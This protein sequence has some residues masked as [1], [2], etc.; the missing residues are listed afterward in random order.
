MEFVPSNIIKTPDFGAMAQNAMQQ[1][2]QDI[3]EMNDWMD[4]NKK[5]EGAYL[6]GDK[7]A[8][9]EAWNAY[10]QQLDKY[11][12]SES[13]EAKRAA[14]E[15]YG[16][17]AQIA[18]V[19]MANAEQYRSQVAEYKADPSKFSI[20]GQ[21]FLSLA[22]EYRRTRRSADELME[23][24]QNPFVIAQSMKYDLADPVTQSQKMLQMSSAK[25]SDF[26]DESGSLNTAA[27]RAYAQKLAKAT[28]NANE[29]SVEKAMAWGGVRSGFAGGE[30][31]MIN[32]M[33]ELE[34]LRNQ[35]EEDR[36]EFINSY[37]TELVNNFMRLLPNEKK[38]TS[39]NDGK[40]IPLS[41]YDVDYPT[42]DPDKSPEKVKFY[43]LAKP[44]ASLKGVVG[45]GMDPRGN[46]LLE[47]EVSVKEFDKDTGDEVTVKKIV[48]RPAESNEVARLN[49][50]ITKDYGV[51][52][53]KI[54]V[55]S[56][57]E[58][59]TGS[60]TD[61]KYKQWLKDNGLDG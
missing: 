56:Q 38:K 33:E 24:V 37:Q 5:K 6:E 55:P 50:I 52:L 10:Q 31:G 47:E 26:Y 14:D 58:S 40:Y 60:M 35:P 9:Q 57:E 48:R 43:A 3:N 45:F 32:S 41:Q 25:I 12:E 2:R 39:T 21:E 30:D 51:S 27:A 49:S 42:S 11:V 34:F 16:K 8:V 36:M 20:G 22:D 23:A 4:A 28:I 13:R 59:N 15:A 19:A 61:E 17:Y 7:P 46:I 53:D 18:G 29:S 44:V 1:K 54:F